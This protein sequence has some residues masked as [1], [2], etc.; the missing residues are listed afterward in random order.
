M[1]ISWAGCAFL[2]GASWKKKPCGVQLVPG[3][4]LFLERNDGL[5][6]G[7]C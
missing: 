7:G 1:G 3:S 2:R 6:V 5:A 4:S